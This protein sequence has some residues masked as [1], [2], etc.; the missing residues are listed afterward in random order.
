MSYQWQNPITGVVRIIREVLGSDPAAE[1]PREK[2]GELL[3]ARMDF[4]E[5]VV[6]SDCRNLLYFI[7]DAAAN[8]WLDL[9][10]REEYIRALKL[11]PQMVDWALE[12]LKATRPDVAVEFA[13]AAEI[14]KKLLTK[15]GDRKSVAFKDQSSNTQLIPVSKKW[16]A[17]YIRARLERDGHTEQLQKIERG[18]TSAHAVAVELGWRSRMV[19]CAPTVDGFVRA[20]RKHLTEAEQTDLIASLAS[21]MEPSIDG[22]P[23]APRASNARE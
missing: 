23:V 6:P 11:E 22:S 18:E 17:A 19:Q 1:V 16:D 7:Q 20:I 3:L 21:R 4:C 12:G 15:G 9:G 5:Q 13:A 14:G 2:W 10:G 8:N